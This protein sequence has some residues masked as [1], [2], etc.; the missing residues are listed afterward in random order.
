MVKGVFTPT[1]ERE[2]FTLHLVVPGLYTDILYIVPVVIL[3]HNKDMLLQ[4]GGREKL[5][6]NK[7]VKES[8]TKSNHI[9]LVNEKYRV[10]K[11][12]RV[13]V[14]DDCVCDDCGI[15]WSFTGQGLSL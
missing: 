4:Y 9:D 7:I 6:S 5:R 11:V 15:Y 2:M 3:Y 14:A 8:Q 12:A 1:R 13:L 10:F